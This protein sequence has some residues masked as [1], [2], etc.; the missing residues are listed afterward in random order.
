MNFHLQFPIQPF[1][2][3]INYKQSSLFLGSCFAESIGGLMQQ[4]KFNATINPHGV[5]Y[6]PVSIAL[7][8]RR[9]IHNEV[10]QEGELFFSNECWNSWEHH[11]RFSNRDK[12]SCLTEIN[13]S[14]VDAHNTVKQAEWLFITLGSAFVYKLNESNKWVSNCHKVPQK[15]F[16]KQLLTVEQITSDYENLLHELKQ[17]NENLKIVFT[18]S[19]V[20]YIRDGVVENN[21]SKARLIGA[22]HELVRQFDNIFYFPAYELVIDDLRDYR[23][24]KTD[25]VHPSEQ[26][27]E[28][29]FEKFRDVAFDDETKLLFQ[30]I[31]EIITASQHRSSDK[32]AMEYKKFKSVNLSKCEELLQR[33]PFLNFNEEVQLFA[34]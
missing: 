34:N 25:L 11:S 3:N 4:Y 5:L 13:K 28:Y 12:Q 1:S 7:A 31:K 23:F 21:L 14:I 22:V 29:V 26:A 18:V 32:N 24:F 16:T 30:K 10:M 17:H 6:N 19:P 9:Y 15:E 33:F 8:L 2:S 27:I 20:R